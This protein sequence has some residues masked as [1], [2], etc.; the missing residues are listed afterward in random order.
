MVVPSPAILVQRAESSLGMGVG[1]GGVG[2][3]LSLLGHG[4]RGCS[5]RKAL[6]EPDYYGFQIREVL[7][8]RPILGSE[9][10]SL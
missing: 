8:K 7:G 5:A 4:L 3:S 9:L 2:V 6:W 1:W 10:G